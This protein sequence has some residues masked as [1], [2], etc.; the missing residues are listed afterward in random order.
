MT[1]RGG[2]GGEPHGLAGGFAVD[3][4]G[5]REPEA[6]GGAPPRA[7]S[8]GTFADADGDKLVHAVVVLSADDRDDLSAAR[9]EH[10][11]CCGARATRNH[12]PGDCPAP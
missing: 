2:A 7:E 9:A 6:C 3:A 4:V 1:P 8:G 10:A 12:C 5:D 11:E